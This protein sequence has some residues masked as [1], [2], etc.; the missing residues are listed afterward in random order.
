[1]LAPKDWPIADY[2]YCV[3]KGIQHKNLLQQPQI[4]AG[5]VEVVERDLATDHC[6]CGFGRRKTDDNE[7]D[8]TGL[9]SFCHTL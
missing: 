9:F 7:Y 3:R 5:P 4:C 1:V 6:Q 8:T 2:Q